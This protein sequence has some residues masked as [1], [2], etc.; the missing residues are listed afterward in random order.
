MMT[1]ISAIGSITSSA[2]D[3]PSSSRQSK[4]L[5]IY[6][7]FLALAVLVYH[8]VAEGAFSAILTLAAVFQCLAIS[9][10]VLQALSKGIQSISVKSL[11]LD[12]LAVA[13]RLCS[14]MF[15]EGYLPF[16]KS[17]DYAYQ[18]FDGLS[19]VML[20]WLLQ[21]V[22]SVRRVTQ[23]GAEEDNL[24]IFPFVL[25]SIVLAAL[26]HGD[27][28]DSPLFDTVWMSSL[29]ISV[30][31][32]LPQLWMMSRTRSS[33][34]ALTCHFVAVMAFSR[35]LSGTW[36]WY[37]KSEITCVPWIGTFQHAFYAVMMAHALHLLLLCDFAY[38][39]AKNVATNGLIAPLQ[40]SQTWSV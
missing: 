28:N 32:V 22:T 18:C 29:N 25:G 11:Q 15:N 12:A 23:D 14:T 40:T 35:L 19:L 21:H 30:V 31:A 4:I 2:S 36:M 5:V 16:D 26:L 3:K 8:L 33:T 9:L 39:Y 34:P 24:Q 38:V 10:L 20:L 13:C 17:G 1:A 27:L 7:V 6:A 37:A